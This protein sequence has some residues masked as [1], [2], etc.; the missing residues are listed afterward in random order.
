ML[1]SQIS[2]AAK[3]PPFPH[4]LYQEFVAKVGARYQ[5]SRARRKAIERAAISLHNGQTEQD[6]LAQLGPPDWKAPVIDPRHLKNGAHHEFW[7]YVLRMG[8]GATP[9]EDQLLRIGLRNHVKPR[10]VDAVQLIKPP[11]TT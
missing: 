7:A 1:S 2:M 6:V 3:L 4:P 5:A 8:Y 9:D 10:I 11:P